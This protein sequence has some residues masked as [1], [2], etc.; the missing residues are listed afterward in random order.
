[1][2]A[3]KFEIVGAD[4]QPAQII[5]SG[6]G[7][8]KIALTWETAGILDRNI[9][10]CY[11]LPN[12]EPG[13]PWEIENPRFGK[14]LDAQT[15]LTVIAPMAGSNIQSDNGQTGSDVSQLPYWMQSKLLTPDFYAVRSVTPITASIHMLP[16]LKPDNARI[17]TASYQT[18][19][20]PDGSL[21]CEAGFKIEYRNAFSWR[22]RLPNGSALLDC[23]VN[24]NPTSPIVQADGGLELPIPAP[25]NSGNIN[26]LEVLISYTARGPKFEPVEG[27][28]SLALPST[29]L[30]IERL[31]WRLYLPDNYE[32]TAFEG[33]VE[34][35]S[36]SDAAIVFTKRLTR[37]E[38]PNLEVYYRRKE[39]TSKK[40]P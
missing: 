36:G 28:L 13:R 2:T 37:A 32:A 5:L 6:P 9:I 34:P 3:S 17:L 22:F 26:S 30:F 27:K 33:N 12:P 4:L 35:G 16:V 21:K 1:M 29:Q 20:V 40:T 18:G 39:G 8:R 14:E 19:L 11:E 15:S 24:S 7:Q 38:T 25:K 10:V 23:Q 31:E